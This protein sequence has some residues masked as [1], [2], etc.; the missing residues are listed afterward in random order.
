MDLKK[1][2]ESKDGRKT[3]ILA[4]Q[5]EDMISIPQKTVSQNFSWASIFSAWHTRTYK[6]AYNSHKINMYLIKI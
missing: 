6:Y 3:K 4:T 1:N 5:S 2:T